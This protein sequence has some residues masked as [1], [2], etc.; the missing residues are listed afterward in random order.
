MGDPWLRKSVVNFGLCG[1][2]ES[3]LC[4]N[5]A[6]WEATAAAA[7]VTPKRPVRITAGEGHRTG[8]T[9]GALPWKARIHGQFCRLWEPLHFPQSQLLTKL[10]VLIPTKAVFDTPGARP[11]WQARKTLLLA[12]IVCRRSWSIEPP[13]TTRRTFGA[14]LC[15]TRR[16]FGA[17]ICTTRRTFGAPLCTTRRTFGAPICTTRRTFGAPLCTTRRTSACFLPAHPPH[18][19]PALPAYPFPPAHPPAKDYHCLRHLMLVFVRV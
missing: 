12:H 10:E 3:N 13:C 11:F 1:N 5:V 19:R 15:T 14:P 8:G 2:Q 18:R 17:P 6:L 16:T 7:L 4:Q 9:G